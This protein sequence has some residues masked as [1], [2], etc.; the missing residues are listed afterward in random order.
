MSGWRF[1]TFFIKNIGRVL[2]RPQLTQ[3]VHGFFRSVSVLASLGAVRGPSRT[4]R[5]VRCSQR[6]V[7]EQSLR[8]T[9]GH[10]WCADESHRVICNR[11]H[12]RGWEKFQVRYVG[13]ARR[14][15]RAG[16]RGGSIGTS[17]KLR[18]QDVI[19]GAKYEMDVQ[20]IRTDD[21]KHRKCEG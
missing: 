4:L 16:V 12:I 3:L 10:R 5:Q 19:L 13:G 8:A 2:Q 17:F 21:G 1:L 20:T 9:K 6:H 15:K 18:A 14:A 7:L 11:G